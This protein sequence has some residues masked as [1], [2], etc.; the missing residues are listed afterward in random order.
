VKT[1]PVTVKHIEALAAR[2]AIGAKAILE[3]R[4]YL[5]K[6]LAAGP[7]LAGISD[8]GVIA[9]MGIAEDQL[10]AGVFRCWAVTDPKLTSKYFLS[11]CYAMRQ[12]LK[13]NPRRRVE[14]V[15]QLGN[16]QGVRWVEA[17]G[18]RNPRLMSNFNEQGSAW[19]YEL[20]N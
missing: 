11:V 7:S 18:F 12:F 20:V 3:T 6:L 13:D 9:T 10:H 16:K 8:E 17:L 14:T 4:G 5:D 1:E 2:D 15:V 19:L